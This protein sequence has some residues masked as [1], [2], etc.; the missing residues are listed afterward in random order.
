MVDLDDDSAYGLDASGMFAHI[1]RL[2]TEFERAWYATEASA[3]PFEGG[4]ISQLIIAGIGGSAAAGDYLVSL[5]TRT[6]T[7]P[8][9]VV[10]GYGLPAY[11]GPNTLV[12]VASYSGETAE[13]LACYRHAGALG[14]P[15]IA[16]TRG[17]ELS[18]AALAD[19]VT[20]FPILV[21]SPPRAALPHMLAALIR[22]A[23]RL[24]LTDIDDGWVA[25]ATAAHEQLVAERLGPANLTSGNPA[26]QLAATLVNSTPLVM[27]AEPLGPAAR[28]AKNQ[29]AENAKTIAAFEVLP[30]A[31]HNL[32]VGL[33]SAATGPAVAAWSLESP[34]D[35]PGDRRRFEVLSE[36][37]TESGVPFTRLETG[38]LSPLADL[39]Q[40]TAYGDYV[41]CYLALLKGFDPT[42][43]EPITRLKRAL[44]GSGEA[45]IS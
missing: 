28:R 44:A 34:L 8:I 25:E 22:I 36:Q 27:S 40:A 33:E 31:G 21:E 24:R 30:E 19:G 9:R 10:R 45:V 41:S 11:A 26:K 39:L 23:S 16:V 42:P 4:A 37:F 15:R 18:A 14:A 7:I 6:A 38:G 2:G 13:A 3:V 12:V 35:E 20:T 43:V 17:G 5:L 29:L 1:A 32:V